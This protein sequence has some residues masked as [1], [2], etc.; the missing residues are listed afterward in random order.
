MTESLLNVPH[1][2]GTIVLDKEGQI[3][4]SSGDLVGPSGEDA[5]RVIQSLLLDC[6]DLHF[7]KSQ[8]A[9]DEAL[10]RL[11]IAFPGFQYVVAFSDDN[12][13]Y[14]VKQEGVE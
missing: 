13:V 6:G 2:V 9:D 11:T 7:L 4:S 1:Q 12:Q 10:E 5:A 8:S 14:V 3:V